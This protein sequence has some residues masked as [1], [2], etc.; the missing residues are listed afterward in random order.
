MQYNFKKYFLVFVLFL[1]FGINFDLI[2]SENSVG[3]RNMVMYD[4]VRFR[5]LSVIVWYPG[6]T[7]K[8]SNQVNSSVFKG[9]KGIE[10]IPISKRSKKYPLLLLSHGSGGNNLNLAWLAEYFVKRGYIAASVNH[11]NNT[12][13]QDSVFGVIRVWHRANDFRFILDN[14]LKKSTFKSRI[15]KKRIFAVGHSMGGSSVL[16]LK[17]AKLSFK[18]FQN[19]LD[20]DCKSQ[21]PFFY[22]KCSDIKK[23]DFKK[24]DPKIVETSYRDERIKAVVALDPGYGRSLNFQSFN[25]LKN[26][27]I[28]I[29]DNKKVGLRIGSHLFLQLPKNHISIVDGSDHFSFLPICTERGIRAN[30]PICID[31]NRQKIHKS[32]EKR[33]FEFFDSLQ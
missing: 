5:K 2:A 15:D 24:F 28:L 4:S 17:G 7:K 26:Y 14:L 8:K 18:K 25:S 19:P 6:D 11:P 30:I 10:K 12:T 29:A 21:D 3:Y 16:L 33:V 9:F 20:P 32:V 27:F 1:V 23:V 22:E 31:K 13:G